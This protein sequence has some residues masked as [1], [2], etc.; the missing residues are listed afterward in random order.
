MAV[1][2]FVLLM[3]TVFGF[4]LVL[5]AVD[6]GSVGLGLIA[7]GLFAAAMLVANRMG[8]LKERLRNDSRSDS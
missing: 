7:C 2:Y 3:L 8:R 4:V 5:G 1:G 6:Q